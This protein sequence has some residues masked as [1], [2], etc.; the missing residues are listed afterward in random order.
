MAHYRSG[1]SVGGRLRFVCIDQL[2]FRK[3]FVV[4]QRGGAMGAVWRGA[5]YY[6]SII[7]LLPF[8][9]YFIIFEALVLIARRKI[10]RICSK[11]MQR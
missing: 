7:I 2:F 8:Y 5:C 4:P 9:Y 3:R 11:K 6:H 10:V 1:I